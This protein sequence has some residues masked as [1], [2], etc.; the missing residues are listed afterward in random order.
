MRFVIKILFLCA[1]LMFF[2]IRN[3]ASSPLTIP[4]EEVEK[5]TGISF[6]NGNYR[7]AVNGYSLK[8]PDK[9]WKFSPSHLSKNLI[10]LD[11]THKSGKYGLQVR[12][13]QKNARNFAEFVD[14]YIDKFEKDMK[15]P[16]LLG[17]NDFEGQNVTGEAISFD[18][19]QRNGYFLKSYVFP[20]ERYYFALQGGCPYDRRKEIEPELDKIAASF[21]N[22]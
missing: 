19:R 22:L 5:E 21:K 6:F 8:Q 10:K 13:H 4:T 12:V 7:D 18:G 20:G 1:T 16:P 15:N 17:Q 3:F 2:L 14:F 9:N 11:I